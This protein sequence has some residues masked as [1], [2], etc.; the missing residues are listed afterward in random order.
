MAASNY[1]YRSNDPA[2]LERLARE[3]QSMGRDVLITGDKLTVFASKQG[4]VKPKKEERRPRRRD[5]E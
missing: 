3:Y 4:R 2:N 1:Y 5:E